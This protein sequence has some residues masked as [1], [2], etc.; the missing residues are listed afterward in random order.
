[1]SEQ[2]ESLKSLVEWQGIEDYT[3]SR[4]KVKQTLTGIP[5]EKFWKFWN[6]QKENLKKIGLTVKMAGKSSTGETYV[7]DGVRRE[8]IK[9]QWEVILWINA[10]NAHLSEMLYQDTANPF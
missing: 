7:R 1:M 4:G 8:R 5:G 6:T 10:H 9:K 2:I 3:T